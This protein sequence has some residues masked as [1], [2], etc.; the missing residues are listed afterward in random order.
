MTPE[1]R[2]QAL[3]D[4]MVEQLHV[5]P[6]LPGEGIAAIAAAIREAVAE[7]RDACLRIVDTLGAKRG[8][9]GEHGAQHTLMEASVAMRA[10]P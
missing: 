8:E 6:P 4:A 3:H 7:E 1:E 5:R 2:A 9:L 10:R